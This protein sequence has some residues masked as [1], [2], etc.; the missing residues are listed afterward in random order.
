[1]L[2]ATCTH[3]S[4][5]RLEISEAVVQIRDVHAVAVALEAV[6]GTHVL[7]LRLHVREVSRE[8]I[9]AAGRRKDVGTGTGQGR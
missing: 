6:A 9:H 4:H 3:T 5:Q 2:L 1:M 8:R 7:H